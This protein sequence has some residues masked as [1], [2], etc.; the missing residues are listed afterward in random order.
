MQGC[1][2]GATSQPNILWLDAE[3]LSPDLGCYGTDL[4]HTPNL[5]RLASEGVLFENAFTTSPVCS[6]SR[7]SMITGV[8]QTTLGAHHHRPLSHYKDGVTVPLPEDVRPITAYLREAGYFCTNGEALTDG[9]RGKLGYS[10]D[11]DRFES[12]FDGTDWTQREEG[13]PFFAEIHFSETHRTFEH[14]PDNPIDPDEVELP[15][16]YPDHP[17]A[18]LDWALYLETVQILDKKVGRVLQRLEDDGL[19]GNTVVFFNS[20]HGR[21]MLRGKQWCYD[22]GIHVPLIVRWPG[23]IEPGTVRSDLIS[24][25]DYAPTWLNIAGATLP[26]YLQGRDMFADN[27]SRREYIYAARDR[28]DE[29]DYRIRTVRGKKYKYIRN[30]YPE[31]P[32][33]QFSAYKKRE[34]PVLTLM[35]HLDEQ[36]ELSP[37]Q[38]KLMASFRDPEELYDLETDP[39]EINNL[40]NSEEHQEILQQYRDELDLWLYETDDQ[41]RIQEHPEDAALID[42]LEYEEFQEEMQERGLSADVPHTEYLAWWNERLSAIKSR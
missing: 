24:A 34:Y 38:A 31:R 14:D 6:P 37:P 1:A 29:A 5:D 33:T 26:D 17:L 21:P 12:I 13:Q 25:I 22:S 3:D 30:Y 2:A 39:F 35:Q 28:C 11:Y 23:Q 10:F 41:G 4:V 8:H 7:T 19:A 16:Y 9:E 15:P 18:R 36:D 20:D 40:V 42:Q 32:F 27:L